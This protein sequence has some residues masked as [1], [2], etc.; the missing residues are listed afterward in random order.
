MGKTNAR[1]TKKHRSYRW[2]DLTTEKADNIRDFYSKVIGWQPEPVSIGSK[3]VTEITNLGESGRY[4][5]IE[6]PSGAVVPCSNRTI[7]SFNILY[8]YEAFFLV[9]FADELSIL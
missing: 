8:Y 7:S 4:C 9:L 3:I 1:K 6:D 5:I 2:V